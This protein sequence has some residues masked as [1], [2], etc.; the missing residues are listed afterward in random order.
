MIDSAKSYKGVMLSLQKALPAK[1]GCINSAGFGR[2]QQALLDY[3]TDLHVMPLQSGA[4]PNCSLYLVQGDKHHGY[5][6]PSKDWP[7]EDWK[8][9]WQGKRQ[10][11]RHEKFSLYQKIN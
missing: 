2:S 10:A 3:Y 1:H 8:V 11:D 4:K 7:N 6:N 5:I 9:I